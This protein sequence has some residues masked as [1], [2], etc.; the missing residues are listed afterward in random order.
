MVG[1]SEIAYKESMPIPKMLSIKE[2]AEIE[3]DFYQAAKKALEAGFDVIEIHAAHGYL[4][5]TFL[6]PLSNTRTD[7]YG[8]NLQGR[9]KLVLN[10]CERILSDYKKNITLFVRISATEYAQ[11]G[12]DIEE[13]IAL[14]KLLN[15]IGVDLIDVSSGG[16][17]Q[18]AKIS[19]FD[20]YQVG[21]SELIKAN[22]NIATAAVGMI[23]TMQQAEEILQKNQADL[24]F[25]GRLLLRDPYLPLRYA[26]KMNYPTTIPIQYERGF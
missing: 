6:S 26:N 4:L 22:S 21:F 23:N 2:I 17:I 19:L 20:E 10:I 13:S 14:A 5:H 24:I 8:G 9:S 15:A 3:E 18:N 7:L 1:P 16:N 25:M 12:W 11:G